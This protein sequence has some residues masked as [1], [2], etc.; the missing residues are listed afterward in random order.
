MR[1]TAPLLDV[2]FHQ[3]AHFTT[4]G[5]VSVHDLR[6]A[7]STASCSC[8]WTGRRR[9][10]KAAAQQDAWMHSIREGCDVACPLVLA[11]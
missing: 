4:R 10:L 1:A 11:R 2:G 5:I 9:H 8:G 7:H 6:F 3:P